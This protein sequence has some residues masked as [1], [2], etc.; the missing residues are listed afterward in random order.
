MNTGT[1]IIVWIFRFLVGSL[2]I[3][4]GLVKANDSLGFSYKLEEYFVEFGK[5]F[6][7]N[8]LGFLATPMEWLENIALPLAM[9]I[10]VLEIVLGILTI[11]GTKMKQVSILLLFL[12]IF[13]T[14]LT[15]ASWK[16]E[17]VKSC[18]CFGDFIPLTPFE[19]FL[20]DIALLILIIPIFLAS[21]KIDSILSPT[22]DKLTILSSFIVFFLFTFYSYNHLPFSDHRPYKIGNSLIQQMNSQP[23]N[24]LTLYKLQ[25]NDNGAVTEM[26]NYPDDYQNWSP[27]INPNDSSEK[28]F[29]SVEGELL[30]KH[31]KVKSTGQINRV[32]QIPNELADD[33][34]LIKEETSNFSPDIDPKI[35]DLTAESIE[36]NF[37]NKIDEMLK[38]TNYRIVLVVRSLDF[39]GDF[40]LA[41]DGWHFKKSIETEKYYKKFQS[42]YYDFKR[43]HKV[44]TTILTSENDINKIDA[45][46]QGLKTQVKLYFCADKELKTMIRSSPGL[47][48]WKKDLVLGKWHYYDLPTFEEVKDNILN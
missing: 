10:V 18:G 27:Y 36:D 16:W 34:E 23:G 7:D 8:G 24:P 15:F 44:Y 31:V 45:F 48:L 28:Y 17:L 37:E 21:R 13:F 35:F 25:N 30:I 32:T 39:F 41:N 1:K 26:A 6:I 43:E 11:T 19:S 47:F 5:I 22:G 38:D 4:S 29:R 20:K 3:F 14:F 9:F 2:F 40:S 46:K 33:W 12:I 42:L